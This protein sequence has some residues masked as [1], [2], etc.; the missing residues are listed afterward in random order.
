PLSDLVGFY[1]EANA[2]YGVARNY[3]AA[4]HAVET[5]F[6]RVRSDSV[7]GAKGPMQFIPSTWKIYGHGGDIHDPHDAILAA[8]DLLH[9]NGAPRNYA[10]ALRAYNPSGLYVDAVSRYAKQIAR[11]PYALYFLYCWLP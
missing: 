3:L 7:A 8:A 10:R 6:G 2:T 5:K 11:D 4:I 9:H 1:H